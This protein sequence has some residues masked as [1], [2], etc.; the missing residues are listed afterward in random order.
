M[1]GGGG[2]GG[3]SRRWAR[4]A[5]TRLVRAAVADKRA[6][7]H[8]KTKQ[9]RATRQAGPVAASVPAAGNTQE[10][11]HPRSRGEHRLTVC[12]LGAVGRRRGGGARMEAAPLAVQTR[13]SG[14][15]TP[16]APHGG[17]APTAGRRGAATDAT[18]AAT[19]THAQRGRRGRRGAVGAAAAL[20]PSPPASR[21]PARWPS[22][23][24]P[25]VAPPPGHRTCAWDGHA[26]ARRARRLPLPATD[27]A[28]GG[29]GGRPG[30]PLHPPPPPR[31]CPR[32]VFFGTLRPAEGGAA[33]P[34]TSLGRQHPPPARP[35]SPSP[36]AAAIAATRCL[37]RP[38]RT[39]TT[40]PSSST[41]PP[42]AVAVV[43]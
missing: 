36:P 37:G 12:P 11:T 35:S 13:S 39:A 14:G 5:W 40:S 21:P 2:G 25:R 16:A 28:R 26:P 10:E 22:R 8:G 1:M 41:P 15:A 4:S 3:G 23:R 20:P 29:V 6:T 24:R 42:A 43:V 18:P 31:Y 30:T 34:F 17:R 32:P 33:I 19:R 38:P 27:A 9:R 7:G